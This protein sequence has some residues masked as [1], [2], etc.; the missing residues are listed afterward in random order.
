ML[1]ILTAVSGLLCRALGT[2]MCLSVRD[3]PLTRE[4][5]ANPSQVIATLSGIIAVLSLP[6]MQE[7][8]APVVRMKYEMASGDPERARHARRHLGP[9]VQLGRW[10]FLW[11]NLSRPVVLLTHSLICFVLSLYM[12]LIYGI[13]YLMFATFS[14]IYCPS[15][16]RVPFLT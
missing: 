3:L 4:M 2:N 12:A 8:Y 11:I 16:E 15:L 14:G 13:Y 1:S 10:K 5:Q 7:S 6:F 9:E